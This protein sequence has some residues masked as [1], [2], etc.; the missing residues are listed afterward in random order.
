MMLQLA[1]C[2]EPVSRASCRVMAAGVVGWLLPTLLY[3][4]NMPGWSHSKPEVR[5]ALDEAAGVGLT[6]VATP[7]RHGHSW[8]YIACT[9]PDCPPRMRRMYVH[10]TPASQDNHARDIRRFIRRHEHKE[11]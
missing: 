10:S 1:C 6:V 9:H 5:R 7:N 2:L 11:R 4:C 3:A 8:G